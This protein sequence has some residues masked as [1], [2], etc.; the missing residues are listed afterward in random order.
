MVRASAFLFTYHVVYF[1]ACQKPLGMERRFIT[2]AQISASSQFDVNHAAVK[3][4]LHFKAG[5]GN[6]GAWSAAANNQN[7]FLQVDLG[8]ETLVKVIGTQ[9][10]NAYDQCVTSYKLQYSNDGFSFQ[11][12]KDA[13]GSVDKVSFH[14]RSESFVKIYDLLKPSIHN[15]KK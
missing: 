8:A 9:G 6:Q 3:A 4:R 1:L 5:G 10:R 11:Y 14:E 7:Q 15:H 2:D 13:G 12:H